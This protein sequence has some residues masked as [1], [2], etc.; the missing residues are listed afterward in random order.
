MQRPT[1][2]ITLPKSKS[3]VTI[4]EFL[5]TKEN[6]DIQKRV[7]SS[8][9]VSFDAA[10]DAKIQDLSADATFELQEIALGYLIVSIIDE[11][12]VVATDIRAYVGELPASDGDVLYA[13][14]NEV[15]TKSSLDSEGKKK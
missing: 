7:L 1:I 6:R 3:V 13:K 12:G 15:T 8:M 14:L 10:N 5:T 2:T 9:K 4:Y 11:S